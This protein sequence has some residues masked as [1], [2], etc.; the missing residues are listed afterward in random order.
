MIYILCDNTNLDNGWGTHTNQFIKQIKK[1]KITIICRKRNPKLKF[2]QIAILSNPIEYFK[3]PL[4]IFKDAYKINKIFKKNES[5]SCLHVN[6]E[7]YITLV[8]FLK[9]KFKKIIFTFHGSYFFN[10]SYGKLKFFFN[11]G[12]KSCTNIVFVSNYTKRKILPF[13]KNNKKT[14]KTVIKNGIDVSKFYIKKRI[15]KKIKILC[16]SA[17]KP[18]KGQLNVIKAMK[19]IKDKKVDFDIIFAGEIQDRS[20]FAQIIKKVKSYKLEDFCKFKNYVS[21][22]NKKKL[23]LDSNLF[24]LLSE[25]IG[26]S[27]EGFGLVYLE[28]LSYGTPVIISK[29]TG[30]SDLKVNKNNGLLVHPKQYKLIAKFIFN[31]RK[32]NFYNISKQS[33]KLC[34]EN[35][36]SKRSKQINQLYD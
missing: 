3:N 22:K 18:R 6:V 8:P 21:E 20:Y 4:L 9:K 30:A 28:A 11:L 31:L 33:I 17:I 1:K 16:L 25:D 19:I 7:P 27:F 36:W 34:K 23:F 13:L 12:L 32:K 35:V 26:N 10:L 5:N 2:K 24:I 29:K 15:N 14:K